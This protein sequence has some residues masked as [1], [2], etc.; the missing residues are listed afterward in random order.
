VDRGERRVKLALL[1]D[2]TQPLL[3][4]K[5]L[6][7]HLVLQTEETGKEEEKEGESKE[8]LKS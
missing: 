1:P 8:K 4:G 2:K 6:S 7:N 5:C 3:F